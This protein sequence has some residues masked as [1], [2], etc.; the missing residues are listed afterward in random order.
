MS[1]HRHPLLDNREELFVLL[2]MLFQLMI[3]TP[4]FRERKW[5]LISGCCKDQTRTYNLF[6]VFLHPQ[7][8]PWVFSRLSTSCSYEPIWHSTN[9]AFLHPGLQLWQWPMKPTLQMQRKDNTLPIVIRV[10]MHILRC[11]EHLKPAGNH[12]LWYAVKTKN[13]YKR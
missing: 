9:E 4:K 3:P 1:I 13:V 10:A 5:V 2:S 8:H 7:I 12:V 11:K 6:D